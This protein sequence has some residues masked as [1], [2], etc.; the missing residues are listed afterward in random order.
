MDQ[1]YLREITNSVSTG[2]ISASLVGKNAGKLN[3][4]RRLAT[5]SPS[6]EILILVKYIMFVYSPMWFSMKKN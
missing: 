6:D 5:A 1:Q 3:H 2:R 4:L